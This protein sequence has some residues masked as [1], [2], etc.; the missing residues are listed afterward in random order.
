MA[1]QH[2]IMKQREYLGSG[3]KVASRWGYHFEMVK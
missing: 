3:E 2:L 1:V